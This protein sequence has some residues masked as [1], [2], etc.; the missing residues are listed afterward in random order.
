[1]V[2]RVEGHVAG[3]EH[4]AGDLRIALSR[5]ESGDAELVFGIVGHVPVH[6][7][8]SRVQPEKRFGVDA[9]SRV[10]ADWSRIRCDRALAGLLQVGDGDGIGRSARAKQIGAGSIP[11]LHQHCVVE[12]QT[13]ETDLRVLGVIEALLGLELLLDE[14]VPELGRN[15]D[16][17][18]QRSEGARAVCLFQNVVLDGSANVDG[19]RV[20]RRSDC[21]AAGQGAVGRVGVVVPRCCGAVVQRLGKAVEVGRVVRVHPIEVGRNLH[22]RADGGIGVLHTRLDQP[23]DSRRPLVDDLDLFLRKCHVDF[24]EFDVELTLL[25]DL[26]FGDIELF[27]GGIRSADQAVIPEV[28][29]DISTTRVVFAKILLRVGDQGSLLENVVNQ[30]RCFA[31]VAMR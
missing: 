15:A 27:A 30:L 12:L 22:V 13:I 23:E 16:V 4:L 1:M 17:R 20:V 5:L 28:L 19:D 14:A 25:F 9:S 3:A 26:G 29:C 10:A 11:G 2:T 24:E 31:D 21:A 8:L 18:F 6:E 7:G